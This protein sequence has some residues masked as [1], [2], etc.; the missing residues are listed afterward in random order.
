[1]REQQTTSLLRELL[2][3]D[4]RLH[5]C[6]MA[7]RLGD[8]CRQI[9][10][11]NYQVIVL[12][13]GERLQDMVS[14]LELMATTNPRA[15]AVAVLEAQAI[16][17]L[18][19][20]IHPKVL[21]YVS[22][23]DAADHLA[24]AVIEVS[25]GR[26]TASP[27]LSDI[28]MRLT[29]SYLS[30]N[31]CAINSNTT[32]R[33]LNQA[34]LTSESASDAAF[35]SSTFQASQPPSSFMPSMQSSGF[36]KN[37]GFASSTAFRPVSLS[38]RETSILI[39]IAQGASSAEIGQELAISVHTVNTHIRNI[40]VKLGVQTRAQAIHVGIAQGL[41][42]LQWRH[43]INSCDYSKYSLIGFWPVAALGVICPN[44]ANLT[45]AV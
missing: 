20:M 11:Q 33:P 45:F 2:L 30:E 44:E 1:V 42:E 15:K 12:A 27:A 14:L 21:G 7:E 5:I 36:G 29:S 8:A 40:F 32:S 22:A 37:S 31:A 39:Q 13:I 19:H 16:T 18:Q 23:Q 41:I 4:S 43:L 10:T 9:R 25:Q 26:F 28:V 38:E 35:A 34:Y 17:Q 3:S 6:A 24:D